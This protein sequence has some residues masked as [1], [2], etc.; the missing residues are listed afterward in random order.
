MFILKRVRVFILL[1]ASFVTSVMANCPVGD[2]NWDCKVNLEDVRILTS[3]W[4]DPN[5]LAP[6][7]EADIDANSGVNMSE[8]SLL[9]GDWQEDGGPVVHIKWLGHSSFKI[10][11][12]NTIIY[13]DPWKLKEPAQDANIVLVSHIHS[14][15]YS[16]ADIAKIWRPQTQ[17]FAPPDVIASAG[18]GQAIAPGQT[19][20]AGSVR[21]TGVASYNITKPNHPKSKNWL[22]FIVEI[23]GIRLYYAGDTDL[24]DEMKALTNIEVALLPVGGTYTMNADEA[25]DATG[26]FTPRLAIPCH[27]GDIV[28]TLADAQRFASLAHCDVRILAVN[29]TISSADWFEDLA[30]IAHWKLD[31]AG[32]NLAYDYAGGNTGTLYGGP[33][34]QP[35]GGCVNGAL[36][37][38]GNN[39]YVTAG[40]V[41][42]P[43][44]GPFSIFG[45]IKTDVAGRVAISQR[46]GTGLGRSWLCT[47]S[48]DGKLMT[49]IRAPG[50]F[51]YPL[52]SES[53]ITDGNWHHI[54]FVW[55]GA[56]RHLYVD[57]SE[58]IEDTNAQAGLES[59][60]GGLY[61]GVGNTLGA[62][63]FWSGLIDDVRIYD[64]AV[65]P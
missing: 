8:F 57:Y 20:Q 51:G 12:S 17:L 16:S 18:K 65:T 19:I 46:S 9:A 61:F 31:E 41:L 15:H 37:L 50:R 64:R 58:V 44:S 38:D 36:E 26:F 30:L 42:N 23:G 1:S 3:R 60:D 52:I 24:T 11:D 39:D 53:I 56:R 27:W 2:L 6:G 14:D 28:G 43:A 10:W 34:W 59:A 5:C 7:C 22:G 25:A 35:T 32:G 33:V 63:T 29:E 48:P 21:I 13:I 4:L 54:G 47:T 55:D 40:F 45:W 62:T 49:D